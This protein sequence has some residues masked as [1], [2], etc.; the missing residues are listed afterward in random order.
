VEGTDAQA[1]IREFKARLVAE[2]RCN[3][4]DYEPDDGPDEIAPE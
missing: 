1:E 2:F 4:P 3:D